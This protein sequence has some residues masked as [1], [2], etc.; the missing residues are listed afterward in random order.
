MKWALA[1]A[2]EARKLRLGSLVISS[3][4]SLR[5]PSLEGSVFER[6]HSI[7]DVCMSVRKGP[8]QEGGAKLFF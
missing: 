6:L 7:R 1:Y 5:P 4:V 3:K 2:E 8:M